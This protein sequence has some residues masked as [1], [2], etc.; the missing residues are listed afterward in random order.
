M[1][2]AGRFADEMNARRVLFQRALDGPHAEDLEVLLSLTVD[3]IA[4]RYAIGAAWG[5]VANIDPPVLRFIDGS[6]AYQEDGR[7]TTCRWQLS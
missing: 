7:W 4:R 3:E 1:S 2:T 5:E 6:G